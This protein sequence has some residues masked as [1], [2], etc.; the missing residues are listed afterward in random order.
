MSCRW[1]VRHRC[2]SCTCIDTSSAAVMWPTWHVNS[3]W[4]YKLRCSCTLHRS[5]QELILLLVIVSAVAIRRLAGARLIYILTCTS[6][7]RTV[8]FW[9]VCA[10]LYL[11]FCTSKNCK[12]CWNLRHET[13]SSTSVDSRHW[14]STCMMTLCTE[15]AEILLNSAI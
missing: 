6:S 5:V 11:F 1:S 7:R 13:V 2:T 10:H 15:R 3:R 9:L 14:H 4:R 12:N 8:L